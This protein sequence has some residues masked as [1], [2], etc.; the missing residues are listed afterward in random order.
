LS[1]IL[2]A[3]KKAEQNSTGEQRV[4]T[5]WPAPSSV[6]SSS[7]HGIRR[8]L[9]VFGCVGIL[10]VLAVIFWQIRRPGNKILA[11]SVE[12]TAPPVA[13]SMKP[14]GPTARQARTTIARTEAK[15]TKRP[16]AV[17]PVQ[18]IKNVSPA[19]PRQTEATAKVAPSILKQPSPRPLVAKSEPMPA[20]PIAQHQPTVE[21]AH[22]SRSDPRIEL[23]ALVWSP[24]AAS[25]FVIINNRLIKEGGAVDN[26]VVVQINRDDVL[27]SEGVN[28]WYEP[29]KV[30]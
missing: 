25:R 27:L 7:R 11:A 12:K 2:E 28:K 10:V 9:M 5:P 21:N 15:A 23:Q 29:F 18:P 22:A 4:P 19:T 8:W 13:H 16:K 6:S 20:P 14:E 17:P 24:D 1:S 30:R 26:I 3:L